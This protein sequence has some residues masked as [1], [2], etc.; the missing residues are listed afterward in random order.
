MKVSAYVSVLFVLQ[1]EA[2]DVFLNVVVKH[3]LP[4]LHVGPHRVFLNA[5]VGELSNAS[6]QFL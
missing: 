1:V 6:A 4:E 5:A 3:G 2:A